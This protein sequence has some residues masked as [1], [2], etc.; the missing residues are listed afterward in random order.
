M[1]VVIL[2]LL[3]ACGV[4]KMKKFGKH[5]S[6]ISSLQ[7]TRQLVDGGKLIG[8]VILKVPISV[9]AILPHKRKLLFNHKSIACL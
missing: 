4:H 6:V 2:A 8:F 7:V 9:F 5:R 1:S 3:M